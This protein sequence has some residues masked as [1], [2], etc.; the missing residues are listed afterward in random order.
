V[1]RVMGFVFLFLA[2]VQSTRPEYV[3]AASNVEGALARLSTD[4]QEYVIILGR[5][6]K[7][8]L[9]HR[10]GAI[11]RLAADTP[12]DS[13]NNIYSMAIGDTYVATFN[14]QQR[15]EMSV[16]DVSV[17]AQTP[18]GRAVAAQWQELFDIRT[19]ALH[20]NRGLN[21]L[22]AQEDIVTLPCNIQHF[23]IDPVKKSDLETGYVY[24]GGWGAGSRHDV[25]N[26]DAGLQ[27]SSQQS[28]LGDT[29]S[30]Y[31]KYGT[32]DPITFDTR[33]PCGANAKV[34]MLFYPVSK[35]LLRYSAT[36]TLASGKRVTMTFLQHTNPSDG[37]WPDG[38]TAKDGV[39][40]K[41]LISIAQPPSWHTTVGR[42]WKSESYFGVRKDDETPRVVWL[43]CRIGT[44]DSGGS[45]H[46]HNWTRADSYAPPPDLA[47]TILLDYPPRAETAD[48]ASFGQCDAVGIDLRRASW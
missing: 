16:S 38:G 3:A 28:K 15:D 9:L 11:E 20:G 13:P 43:S 41:R 26:V 18:G 45:P 30:V 31:W 5:A 12:S 47:K 33:F 29:Y 37:W 25:I 19:G 21:G 1:K 8:V 40:L 2:L 42:S 22:S 17:P 44:V 35:T 48:N 6:N 10:E 39:I 32:N 23:R 46:L 36:G 7:V 14:G 27:K 24:I 34:E 4:D